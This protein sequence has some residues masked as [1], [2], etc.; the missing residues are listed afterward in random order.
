VEKLVHDT[1]GRGLRTGAIG[2]EDVPQQSLITA[3]QNIL[4]VSRVIL[5]PLFEE[6]LVIRRW[7]RRWRRHIGRSNITEKVGE[8]DSRSQ[9][10]MTR[11]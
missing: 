7:R 4:H 9:V 6:F 11:K 2:R 5:W 1:Q 3:I 8:V 10:D